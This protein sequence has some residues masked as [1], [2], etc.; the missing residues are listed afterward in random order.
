MRQIIVKIWTSPV[1]GFHSTPAISVINRRPRIEPQTEVRPPIDEDAEERAKDL[2]RTTLMKEIEMPKILAQTVKDVLKD[3]GVSL[4]ELRIDVDRLKAAEL[5]PP[6]SIPSKRA[7]L[8]KEGAVK[9]VIQ[10]GER[11]SHAYIASLMTR[12]YACIKRVTEELV[13]RRPDFTPRT[14]LDFGT[15]PATALWALHNTY[16]HGSLD[17]F[18]GVDVSETMLSMGEKLIKSC[19]A[20]RKPEWSTVTLK[21]HLSPSA[22]EQF[23]V[24][25]AAFTINELP[26][27]EIKA[28]MIRT[29]WAKTKSYFIMIEHGELDDY[30]AI[31][32]A[33]NLILADERENGE[34]TVNAHVVAPCP[35]DKTCPLLRTARKE[36]NKVNWCQF[37]QNYTI[38]KD[39]MNM[40]NVKKPQNK[41]MYSYVIMEKG[42]RL[43]QADYGRILNTP[44]KKKGKVHLDICH[45]YGE[46]VPSFE[47]AK[48]TNLSRYSDARHAINAQAW[49][50]DKEDE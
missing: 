46:R 39:A 23:D 49:I 1:R 24:V 38:N 48:A 22:S 36:S 19:T 31:L 6:S 10:Y 9:R 42:P 34:D 37:K 41:T 3:N 4:A 30:R 17:K 7:I 47:V 25:I 14:V 20:R 28:M 35:H 45:P 26:S 21:R 27:D 5:N 11:E 2:P 16:K 12:N 18:V 15:G 29:L 43:A 13:R 32:N 44:K 40:L 50:L 8:W 33:R